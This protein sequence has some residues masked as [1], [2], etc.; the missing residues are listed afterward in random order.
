MKCCTLATPLLIQLAVL[1]VALVTPLSLH[2]IFSWT[3]DTPK[4]VSCSTWTSLATARTFN[5][6]LAELNYEC[7]CFALALGQLLSWESV[8]AD[9]VI[10]L[11]MWLCCNL[12]VA[13][14]HSLVYSLC[15]VKLAQCVT[16]R[17][18]AAHL[19]ERLRT[20]HSHDN[21]CDGALIIVWHYAVQAGRYYVFYTIYGIHLL[22]FVIAPESSCARW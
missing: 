1:A 15:T 7:C 20:R 3:R 12:S 5:A 2:C 8:N 16:Y 22:Q 11:T 10:S 9:T 21:S 18:C 19:T 13:V 4:T 14:T 6:L 17:C